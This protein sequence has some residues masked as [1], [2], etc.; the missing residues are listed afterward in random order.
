[1]TKVSNIVNK[2]YKQKSPSGAAKS[3]S[4]GVRLVGGQLCKLLNTMSHHLCTKSSHADIIL[5]ALNIKHGQPKPYTETEAKLW[6]NY[7]SALEL[8]NRRGN[9][10]NQGGATPINYHVTWPWLAGII[11]GDGSIYLSK[12][13]TT[14]KPVLVISMTNHATVDIIAAKLG[15]T[16]RISKARGNR[17]DCKRLRVLSNV[18][19]KILPHLIPYLTLKKHKAEMAHKI[20]NTRRCGGRVAHLLKEFRSI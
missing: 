20:I 5:N 14:I 17:R 7:C 10:P 6:D 11:D 3:K 19:H 16:S 1:M 15:T 12:F 4:Y 9:C 13:N 8:L 18:L 2:D